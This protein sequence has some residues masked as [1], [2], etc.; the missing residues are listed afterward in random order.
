[1]TRPQPAAVPTLA[2]PAERARTVATR[3]AAALCVAGREPGR[4]LAHATTAD[5]RVLVL[6]PDDGEVMRTLQA[7]ATSD[8]TALLMVSDRAPVPLRDPVRAQLWLSG[9]LTPVPAHDRREATLAFADVRPAGE[10]LDVGRGTTLLRLD[11]AEVVLGEH[12][13]CTEVGLPEYAAARPDP[14]AAVEADM[15][16]HLDRDHPEVLTLLRSRIP[17]GAVGPRDAVRPLGLDRYG[18]RLRIERPAGHADV[19][20]PFPRPLGCAGELRA[21]TAQLLWAARAALRRQG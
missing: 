7:G 10:L 12:G 17:A 19:R 21:A 4:P 8:V 5:G 1:M 15:L 14:L 20:I 18:Y 6:V 11:L 3:A 16:T 13:A 2:A 9:W